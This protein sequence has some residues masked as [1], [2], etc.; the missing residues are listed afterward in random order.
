MRLLIPLHWGDDPCPIV[1]QPEPTVFEAVARSGVTMA[2]VSPAAYRNSGLTR[3][4][5]RGGAYSAAEDVAARVEAVREQV[6]SPRRTY[7]YV[8]WPELDRIGHE[9]G[10]GSATWRDSLARADDSGASG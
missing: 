3:A 7:T 2:T 10:V 4:V 6:A 5:L 9:F 1:V 8:Y